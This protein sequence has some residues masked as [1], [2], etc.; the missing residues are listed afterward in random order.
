MPGSYPFTMLLRVLCERGVVEY[1]LRAGGE[2]VD[3]ADGGGASLMV[4]RDSAAPTRLSVGAGDG[5]E[6]ECAAFIECIRTGVRPIHGTPAQARLAVQ[7]ALAARQSMESGEA[8]I[9]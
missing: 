4:Y 1:T 8:I 6:N 2:Q 5:Y 9:F 3:S 7:T